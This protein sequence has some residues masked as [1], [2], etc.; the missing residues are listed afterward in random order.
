MLLADGSLW[1]MRDLQQQGIARI[2]VR[3]AVDAGWVECLSRGLYR[4]PDL[5][6]QDSAELAEVC[7][8][9]RDCAIC[10]LSAARFHG[11]ADDEPD[12][13]WIAVRNNTRTPLHSWPPVRLVRWR[14]RTAREIGIEIRVIHGVEVKITNPARTV[15]DMLRMMSTVGEDRAY[16][17]LRAYLIGSGSVGE[18][19]LIAE[20]LRVAKRLSPFLKAIPLLEPDHAKPRVGYSKKA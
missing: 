18:V 19:R 10:L 2:T 17:C 4:R 12:R 16:E 15:V 13:I 14:D 7:A 8:Q 11:L 3:R 6:E 1:R 20:R 9:Y 5:P